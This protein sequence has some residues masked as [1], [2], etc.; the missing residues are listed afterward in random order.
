VTPRVA[1]LV[2][3]TLGGAM[4]VALTVLL[5]RVLSRLAEGRQR[6]LDWELWVALALA[7]L[8]FL[9]VRFARRLSATRPWRAE[10]GER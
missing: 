4:A 10:S 7:T 5:F 6:L 1:D 8:G 3:K 2:R 9:W